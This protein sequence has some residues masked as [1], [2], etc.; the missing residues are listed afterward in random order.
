[1]LE[2][3][4]KIRITRSAASILL[5]LVLVLALAVPAGAH[6]TSYCGHASV[7]HTHSGVTYRHVFVEH[8]GS[9]PHEHKKSHYLVDN[10]QQIFLHT[11]TRAC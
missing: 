2:M 3:K 4:S 10:G 6:A 7:T 11:V 5:I 8:W 9:T 1:M